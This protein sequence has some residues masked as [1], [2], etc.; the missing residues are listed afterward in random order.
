M[1]LYR[2]TA[3]F[4]VCPENFSKDSDSEKNRW[5]EASI[6]HKP[7]ACCRVEE[8]DAFNV[9]NIKQIA[10]R[11]SSSAWFDIVPSTTGPIKRR[12]HQPTTK[13]AFPPSPSSVSFFLLD[14]F[15]KAAVSFASPILRRPKVPPLD[16]VSPATVFYAFV[17][18]KPGPMFKPWVGPP[19]AVRRPPFAVRRP[20]RHSIGNASQI[21]SS[22]I[23]SSDWPR[24]SFLNVRSIPLHAMEHHHP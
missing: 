2:V 8:Y 20:S 15:F 18:I 5:F 22:V 16:L 6:R 21:A 9:S 23:L 14:P 13:L 17:R 10:L 7:M 19:S 12:A 1:K 11:H 24:F 4:V 3:K